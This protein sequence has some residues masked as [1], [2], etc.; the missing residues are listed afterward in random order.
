MGL[1]LRGVA[2]YELGPHRGLVLEEL[3]DAMTV[4]YGPNEA[5]KSTLLAGL[6]GVLFG[7]ATHKE[8]APHWKASGRAIA[9]FQ[10][11]DGAVVQVERALHKK[12]PPKI[13]RPDKSLVS[14]D[15]PLRELFPELAGVE[16]LIYNS[17]FTFQLAELGDF[18]DA[19]NSLSSRI[20]TVGM[21][22][23]WA[24][25]EIEQ[26]LQDAAKTIFN[27]DP[28]AKTPKLTQ[29]L[30][31]IDALR[32]EVQ[33]K[34]DLPGAYIELQ[35]HL[36]KAVEKKQ[37]LEG[38]QAALQAE[39]ARYEGD[40]ELLPVWR[41]IAAISEQLKEFQTVPS[42][43]P[44][45]AAR[46]AQWEARLED[47]RQREFQAAQH[48]DEVQQRLE[49]QVV[50]GRWLELA[51]VL[52][53]MKERAS[54]IRE[55]V[56]RSLEKEREIGELRERIAAEQQELSA[57][58]SLHG[59][60]RAPLDAAVV[61]QI[62]SAAERAAQAH[63]QLRQSQKS[64]QSYVQQARLLVQQ[65]PG[66]AAHQLKPAG[67]A[68]A[69]HADHPLLEPLLADP[70]FTDPLFTE[71]ANHQPGFGTERQ[72]LQN[73]LD[74]VQDDEFR[75]S[76]LWSKWEKTAGLRR[77][78]SALEASR[79]RIRQTR[80]DSG[81]QGWLV[82]V[83]GLLALALAGAAFYEMSSRAVFVGLWTLAGSVVL[84]AG[85]L[86]VRTSRSTRQTLN[87]Q[88][89]VDLQQMD[90]LR[91]EF[92]Q[93]LHEARRLSQDIRSLDVQSADLDLAQM[94]DALS[95]ASTAADLA[96][97]TAAF[98]QVVESMKN[99]LRGRK[100]T[101][102]QSLAYLQ[103]QQ[104]V[105]EELQRLRVQWEVAANQVGKAEERLNQEKNAWKLWLQQFG[106]EI[107]DGSEL[108]APSPSALLQEVRVVR[109]IR[110][111]AR[112]LELRKQ[113]FRELEAK[114]N[115]YLDWVNGTLN[116]AFTGTSSALNGTAGVAV[117]GE[118]NK[119]AGPVDANAIAS[120]ETETAAELEP[121]GDT[122]ATLQQQWE[123][124]ARK[125]DLAMERVR[126]ELQRDREKRQL[127]SEVGELNRQLGSIREE[128]R[129]IWEHAA[130]FLNPCGV[131]SIEEFWQLNERAKTK[132]DLM[133]Q[134]REAQIHADSLCGGR[135]N[136]LQRSQAFAKAD[137]TALVTKDLILARAQNCQIELS[138]LRTQLE[139]AVKTVGDLEARLALQDAG[140]V[141]TDIRWR[142]AA[143]QGERAE[144][145]R[146]WARL[147]LAKALVQQAR[148]QFEQKRQPQ[149]LL[150]AS[151]L[152]ERMTSG[153]Y[154]RIGA[155]VLSKGQVQLY[156]VD[157]AGREWNTSVLS[158][159]TREQIY[160]A[161]RLSLI[162]DYARQGIVLP[163]VLDDPLV[164]FD[165]ARWR[166][167]FDVLVEEAKDGQFLYMT[168]HETVQRYAEATQT[169][170]VVSLGNPQL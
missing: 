73:A 29:C 82:P 69:G 48:L 116:S 164:N 80:K 94:W 79:S 7:R 23:Q 133:R 14:G 112:D 40:A 119:F 153:K 21:A 37:T 63:D 74:D 62:Q 135:E 85:A 152:F 31:E 41:Q 45:D 50:D 110:A 141:A 61:E 168:C 130:A 129:D 75:V 35:H 162:R 49:A 19:G 143:A 24:P 97:Q 6:R 52:A 3:P 71:L 166:A 149:V 36:R 18:S 137:E 83:M 107:Q 38:Q 122:A 43:T 32:R 144:L 147:T 111:L 138:H 96:Q 115:A 114:V 163:V 105:W 86:V 127:E 44:D 57:G 47:L 170:N 124:V 142:L 145:A 151:Q 72:R 88:D 89:L 67:L 113:A 165:D 101:L 158:R 46:V 160:L 139:E 2:L 131:E 156:C 78:M 84:A 102:E 4:I 12:S 134:M 140:L 93:G 155:R 28:R 128:R 39:L 68:R 157:A 90:R 161:M 54:G 104:R 34:N 58:W 103:D 77:E 55:Q 11:E 27:P 15:G 59:L 91:L 16:E 120:T 148:E 169:V 123:Q 25:V 108:A 95:N 76:E 51:P 64:E 33:N 87:A 10:R 26:R 106:Y 125:L 65:I 60:Y 154:R 5:G 167:V 17:V 22:G 146:S 30:A 53:E 92:E 98:A 126:L 13:M 132:L 70:L 121:P 1:R 66:A 20:Y 8:S 81:P 117:D 9:R 42:L 100:R 109:S 118:G 150:D 136:F 159:G 56:E 99:T